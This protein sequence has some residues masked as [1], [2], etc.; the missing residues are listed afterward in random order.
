M[1][2]N[3]TPWRTKPRGAALLSLT[4]VILA[5]LSLLA[6]AM[7]RNT[8][9]GAV[10]AQAQ[11]AQSAALYAA[12][13][14][15]RYCEQQWLQADSGFAVIAFS[16][17]GGAAAGELPQAWK[18]ESNWQGAQ[19]VELPQS[20]WPRTDLTRAPECLAEEMRLPA[21]PGLEGAAKAVQITARGYS[22]DYA[23]S[24]GV[25]MRGTSAIVQ[26]QLLY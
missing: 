11:Q 6:L 25:T 19:R 5:A 15:L 7:A 9:G 12:E 3:R 2:N 17:S 8:L 21:A 13:A 16:L 22:P 1:P 14:A 26:A 23:Q 20:L 18:T 24:S 10:Q 4:M